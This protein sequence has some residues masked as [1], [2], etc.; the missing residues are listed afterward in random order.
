M[1]CFEVIS[2]KKDGF[3]NGYLNKKGGCFTVF[4]STQYYMANYNQLVTKNCY[5]FN[6]RRLHHIQYKNILQALIH[7]PFL[8]ILRPKRFIKSPHA[9]NCCRNKEC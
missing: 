2:I 8:F 9:P 6:S 5:G 4:K 3:F 1:G 7:R